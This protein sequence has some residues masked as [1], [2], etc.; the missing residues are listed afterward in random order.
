MPMSKFKNS[1]QTKKLSDK[2]FINFV[3]IDNL[4]VKNTIEFNKFRFFAKSSQIKY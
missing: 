1:L 4:S 2:L 3:D